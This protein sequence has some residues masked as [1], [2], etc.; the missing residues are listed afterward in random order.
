MYKYCFLKIA[1][2][3]V[4]SFIYLL[5]FKNIERDK[6]TVQKRVCDF[7]HMYRSREQY[8]VQKNMFKRLICQLLVIQGTPVD[9]YDFKDPII[10]IR[11]NS[12]IR[13]SWYSA[14]A[15]VLL[16]VQGNVLISFKTRNIELLG[17]R[18][19]FNVQYEYIYP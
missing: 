6:F 9:E 8:S 19:C 15:Y 13:N 1:I 16:G 7:Q 10:A 12:S 18:K 2:L 5:F 11:A 3:C 14:Y 4:S 17:K